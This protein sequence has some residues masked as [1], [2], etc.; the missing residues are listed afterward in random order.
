MIGALDLL[1]SQ[2]F[3]N[4]QKPNMQVY[5]EKEPENPPVVEEKKK[6]EE[7]AK[8]VEKIKVDF[9][10]YTSFCYSGLSDEEED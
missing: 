7:K 10:G 2:Y 6:E 1:F 3:T 4:N 8:E 9:P 5:E